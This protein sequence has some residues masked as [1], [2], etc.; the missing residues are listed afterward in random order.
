MDLFTT[1]IKKPQ[2]APFKRLNG[3]E[4][5]KG[6]LDIRQTEAWTKKKKKRTVDPVYPCVVIQMCYR[7]LQTELSSRN[8]EAASQPLILPTALSLLAALASPS[9]TLGW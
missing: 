8:D 5:T 3:D 6:R 2:M 7:R 1:G 4:I 9:M